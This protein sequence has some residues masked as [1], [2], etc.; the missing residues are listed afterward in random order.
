LLVRGLESELGGVGE[1]SELEVEL[2]K[3]LLESWEN[4]NLH[5]LPLSCLER[6]VRLVPV[7][8]SE[9]RSKL[10]K[11]CLSVFDRFGSAASTLFNA[12]DL[13]DLM[14][15]EI[16]ELTNRPTFIWSFVGGSV[17]AT[18][19]S[20]NSTTLDFLRSVQ[21][22]LNEL[23]SRVEGLCLLTNYSFPVS[24]STPPAGVLARLSSV[25]RE[26]LSK[27]EPNGSRVY[28]FGD[29][30]LHPT[31][32]AMEI[33][34]ETEKATSWSFE[35]SEDGS[36]WNEFDRRSDETFGTV[37]TFHLKRT[38]E[39]RF[40]RIVFS[41]NAKLLSFEVFGALDDS[42]KG[43]TKRDVEW[44][45]SVLKSDQEWSNSIIN[46]LDELRKT[47]DTNQQSYINQINAQ[48]AAFQSERQRQY[49]AWVA[50]YPS[51]PWDHPPFGPHHHHGHGP[52]PGHGPGH[53]HWPP[54]G[55][56]VPW[57][58]PFF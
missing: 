4:E 51:S 38:G 6:V 12:F 35:G 32:Y 7:R 56:R 25:R 53:G 3:R 30:R 16:E 29:C 9:S 42:P 52:G 8:D 37:R 36:N 40:L 54:P 24:L 1:S 11:F 20:W 27:E 49:A 39:S 21:T 17:H 5:G 14:A 48:I 26:V 18:L 23:R 15:R 45:K 2:S 46:N 47:L 58:L 41:G 31:H 19:Q 57:P 55:P 34:N 33:A 28:D 13:N 50:Q 44:L 10:F 43:V 22:E